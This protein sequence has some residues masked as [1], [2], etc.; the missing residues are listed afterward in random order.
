[1]LRRA[2]H[3]KT[4][5]RTKISRVDGHLRLSKLAWKASLL[6]QTEGQT[7]W[8]VTSDTARVARVDSPQFA[9]LVRLARRLTKKKGQLQ[10]YT[11]KGGPTTAKS[12][13][14]RMGNG[15]GKVVNHRRWWGPGFSVMRVV[16]RQRPGWLR[17]LASRCGTRLDFRLE[18]Y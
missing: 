18:A 6:S 14:T 9:A 17:L 1:M 4:Q 8:L 13:G 15:K 10:V 5:F 3:G 12:L 7:W 16:C 11:H 2:G